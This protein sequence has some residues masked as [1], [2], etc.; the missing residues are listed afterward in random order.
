MAKILLA[1]YTLRIR[2]K[3]N[4]RYEQ[5]SLFDGRE[6]FFKIFKNYLGNLKREISHNKEN[7]ELFIVDQLNINKEERLIHGLVKTGEYGYETDLYDVNLR[8]ISHKRKPEEAELIPFYF[9]TFIPKYG[10]EGLI[11]FQRFGPFGIRRIFF[12]KI[13]SL[14]QQSFSDFIIEINPLIPEDLINNYLKNGRI[15]KVRFVSFAPSR[16]IADL[17]N[18]EGYREEI[19]SI[20][21]TI[22][23][24]RNKSLSFAL[25]KLFN[26]LNKKEELG[27]IIEVKDFEFNTIKIEMDLGGVKRTLDLSN[28]G[29]LDLI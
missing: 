18:N 5:L 13:N 16:D 14:F 2:R 15:T 26:F 3:R 25:E 10:D 4:K 28:L 6:D 24:K 12:Q 1:S 22:S 20:E 21:L 23:A 17:Y 29:K 27:R 9:L 19:G 11:F 7:K 8:Q